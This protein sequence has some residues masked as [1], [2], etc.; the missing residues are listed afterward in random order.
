MDAQAIEDALNSYEEAI[1][2]FEDIVDQL[3]E[4][5]VLSAS[6]FSK[7]SKPLGGLKKVLEKRSRGKFAFMAMSIDIL[8]YAV[9]YLFNRPLIND[10]AKKLLADGAHLKT[11]L[12]SQALAKRREVLKLFEKS[13][14]NL[15]KNL[16]S[17]FQVLD[18]RFQEQCSRLPAIAG[19][20]NWQQDSLDSRGT[21][22]TANR[23][24]V[25]LKFLV[26]S[27]TIGYFASTLP[28]LLLGSPDL[29][30]GIMTGMQISTLWIFNRQSLTELRSRRWWPISILSLAL[31]ALAYYSLPF[32]SQEIYYKNGRVAYG[33]E[34]REIFDK[35][36]SRARQNFQR[37]VSL[38]PNNIQAHFYLGLVYE[39]LNRLDL[40][41]EA[42]RIA[43]S[44][45]DSWAD[46]EWANNAL[47]NL[48][49]LY[50]LSGESDIAVG[51]LIYLE[52]KVKKEIDPD[53][54]LKD[55]ELLISI[56]KNLGWAYLNQKNYL[57]AQK[58]LENKA[59]VYIKAFKEREGEDIWPGWQAIPY[60]FLA[61]AL[62]GQ[63]QETGDLSKLKYAANAW[64]EFKQKIELEEF[65]N[66]RLETT[67]CIGKLSLREENL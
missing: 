7:S 35:K 4:D 18:S 67:E 33:D 65:S 1:V 49:R 44:G 57:A 13:D 42:Y 11:S 30:S 58:E 9:R 66:Y 39:D 64:Q 3:F 53:D 48:A 46:Q 19:W 22:N 55:P 14:P 56:H 21:W 61:Q 29:V 41:E 23:V 40:A 36:L 51:W 20:A 24:D 52:S 5:E 34:T 47:N 16:N 26:V 32:L 63:A 59:I 37:A 45:S 43:A 54:N 28:R 8:A 27:C 10:S 6:S 60:C 2:S 31:S 12:A 38:D 25:A 62:E 50:I 15:S 17:K